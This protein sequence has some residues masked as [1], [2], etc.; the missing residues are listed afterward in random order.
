EVVLPIDHFGKHLNSQSNIIDTELA[1][2]N[3][4]ARCYMIC[5]AAIPSSGKQEGEEMWNR[6]KDPDNS[7]PWAQE[8]MDFLQLFDGFL[9]P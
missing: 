3:L 9:P 8:A 5:G 6:K 1:T 4:L 7:V 2:Q